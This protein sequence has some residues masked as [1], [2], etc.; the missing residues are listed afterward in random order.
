MKILRSIGIVCVSFFFFVWIIGSG[1]YLFNKEF[2]K[3]TDDTISLIRNSLTNDN[4]I[5]DLWNDSY[6]Y[7]LTKDTTQISLVNNDNWHLMKINDDIFGNSYF[8]SEYRV[9]ITANSG[10]MKP[11]GFEHVN[12]NNRNIFVPK[13]SFKEI[14]NRPYMA[15][16]D[17]YDIEID[18]LTTNC[19]YLSK[20]SQNLSWDLSCINIVVP[21]FL[22]EWATYLSFLWDGDFLIERELYYKQEN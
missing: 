20:Y 18:N 4:W 12:Y 1:F 3:I 10:Y 21:N 19:L 6:K 7:E 2:T 8:D 14:N 9:K 5:L 22:N 17:W 11:L 16:V 13:Y 15:I